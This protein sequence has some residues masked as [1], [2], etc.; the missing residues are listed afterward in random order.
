MLCRIG[1]G[2]CI[3][4]LAV[5]NLEMEIDVNNL[6]MLVQDGDDA[7]VGFVQK[8]I[9]IPPDVFFIA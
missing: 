2:L 3:Q 9:S 6:T 8:L 5:A 4:N 7:S 1:W